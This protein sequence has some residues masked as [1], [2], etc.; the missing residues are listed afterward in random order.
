MKVEVNTETKNVLYLQGEYPVG[1]ITRVMEYY[2]R[3]S[4][5]FDKLHKN[6]CEHIR[7]LEGQPDYDGKDTIITVLKDHLLNVNAWWEPSMED[8]SRLHTPETCFHL[9]QFGGDKLGR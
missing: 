3:Q 7:A 5:T 1:H 9:R 6:M 8:T 2:V 4:E